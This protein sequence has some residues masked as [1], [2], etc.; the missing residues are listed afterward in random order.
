MVIHYSWSQSRDQCHKVRDIGG[1]PMRWHHSVG[2]QSDE[3]CTCVYKRHDSINS[4]AE[5]GEC[6]GK[7]YNSVCLLGD[8]PCEDTS[9]NSEIGHDF[10]CAFELPTCGGA[11]WTNTCTGKFCGCNFMSPPAQVAYKGIVSNPLNDC[12]CGPD[13]NMPCTED[14]CRARA[15]YLSKSI[16]VNI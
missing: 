11:G 6:G 8:T 10:V 1:V 3:M 4:P 5:S 12:S 14:A 9:E 15:R 7:N 2:S 16:T 13:G